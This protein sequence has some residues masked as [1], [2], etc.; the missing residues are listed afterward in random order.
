LLKALPALQHRKYSYYAFGSQMPGR[1]YSAGSQYRYGFNDKENDPENLNRQDY[2][3]RIYDSRI[4]KFLSIDPIF[5]DYPWNSTYAFAEG[6]VIRCVD[7]DGGEKKGNQYRYRL[8]FR[9]MGSVGLQLKVQAHILGAIGLGGYLQGPTSEGA[10]TFHIDYY[11]TDKKWDGGFFNTSKDVQTAAGGDIL[12]FGGSKSYEKNTSATDE[13]EA[14]KS[15]EDYKVQ[16]SEGSPIYESTEENYKPTGEKFR[17]KIVE[18]EVRAILGVGVELTVETSEVPIGTGNGK[19]LNSN[20]PVYVAP[21]K[22]TPVP[23]TGPPLKPN[24]PSSPPVWTP[25]ATTP[26]VKKDTKLSAAT[27]YQAGG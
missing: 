14:P 12:G 13:N 9:V 18:A 4:S 27:T 8:Y 16:T 20:Y 17:W 26:E 5:R 25:P 24:F 11:A 21:T 2:G 1:K 3:L 7:L 23:Y 15:P 22:P 6:D 10:T 19:E